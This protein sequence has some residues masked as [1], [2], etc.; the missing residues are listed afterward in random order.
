MLP[1]TPSG[2]GMHRFADATQNP[3]SAL[4]KIALFLL[5]LMG[6]TWLRAE[7]ISGTIQDSSGAVIPGARIEITGGDLAQP[8]VTA[9]D[10][11]GKFASPELK[12]GT[13]SVRVTRDGFEPLVKTVDL[14]GTIQLQL[15]LAIAQQQVTINVP[16]KSLAF[17]NS[18]PLYRELRNV[19]L[20]QTY[21]F[22]NFTLNYDV[23]TFQFVKGTLTV[24][25]P[26]NGVETGAIFIG[27]GHFNLK[28]MLRLDAHELERRTGAAEA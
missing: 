18:D 25:N 9:S 27:E 20:G 6:P 11:L 26:V 5:C 16:G 3:V 28:A 14:R 22:D 21:R 13:Y 1:C 10:G 4:V 24:L 19:A 12:A 8:V 7:T 17:A 23:G 2:G 15:T